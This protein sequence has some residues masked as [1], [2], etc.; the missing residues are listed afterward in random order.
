MILLDALGTARLTFSLSWGDR[1][2]M[3]WRC[4]GCVGAQVY[5]QSVRMR[6]QEMFFCILQEMKILLF[7]RNGDTWNTDYHSFWEM[8]S[9]LAVPVA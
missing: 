1:I 3:M 4:L 9:G 8:L 2:A 6:V 7:F 5:V